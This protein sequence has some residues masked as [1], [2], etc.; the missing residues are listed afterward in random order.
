MASCVMLLA[1][2]LIFAA[3][4]A[5]AAD[6]AKGSSS[7]QILEAFDQQ[8]VQ[9][10]NDGSTLSNHKKQVIMF[11][12][13]V[14]LLILLLITGGLGIAMGVY[15]KQ[16]LFVTHMLFAGLTVSLAVVH[17]VVGLVW[18]FPF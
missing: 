10:V 6:A 17:V 11:S 3:P 7:T 12:L 8:Q 4:M 16:H 14:P 13:G 9:R 1:A 18:F 5:H 2:M 15:G